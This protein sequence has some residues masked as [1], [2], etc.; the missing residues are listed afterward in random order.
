MKESK[1]KLLQLAQLTL[2]LQFLVL[3]LWNYEFWQIEKNW[4]DCFSLN[5]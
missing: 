2:K 1:Y 5:L 4:N 3:G